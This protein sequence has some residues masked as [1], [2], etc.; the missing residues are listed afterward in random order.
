MEKEDVVYLHNGILFSHKKWN[1]AICDNVDK[2]RG[3]YAKWNKSDQERQIQHNLI[4]A[5][6]KTKQTN[7]QNETK[8]DS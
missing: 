1:V 8:I 6:I 3:C 5:I 4:Y 2:S 7:K